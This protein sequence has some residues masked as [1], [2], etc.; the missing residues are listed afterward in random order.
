MKVKTK[1]ANDKFYIAILD[2]NDLYLRN[3]WNIPI[4]EGS[5][6]DYEEFKQDAMSETGTVIEISD[7]DRLSNKQ[8]EQ[9]KDILTKNLGLTYNYFNDL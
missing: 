2:L 7:L 5:K 9:F 4:I 3:D 8:I 1:S 6:E